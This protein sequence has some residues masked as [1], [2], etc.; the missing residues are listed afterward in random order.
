MMT[1]HAT[2]QFE[3]KSWTEQPFDEIDGRPKLSRGVMTNAFS[4]D[5][6]GEGRVEA[7]M[8]YRADGAISFVSLERVTGQVGDRTGSFVLQHSGVFELN[9][10]TARATWLVTPGS[11]AGDLR[12]LRGQGGYRWD[13]QRDGQT[14]PFTLDYEVEPP[15]ADVATARN[16]AEL[17]YSETGGLKLTPTRST[18]EITG[19]DQTPLDEPAAGP[20]LARATVKKIFRGDLEGE[21]SAELLLCQADDGSA[22]Y[23]GLERVVGRLAGRTGSF[24]V[25]HNAVRSDAAQGG[26]WFVVP[27]SATGELRGLRGRAE[28][29]HDEH[30]AVFTLDY[31]FE[32]EGV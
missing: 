4:G 19:W 25:Q 24:V 18:F 2:G 11:G 31:A 23:I 1:I 15:A 30:E 17:S 12:G 22:G 3:A 14:T 21:S 5:I 29:R 32:Q 13:R 9:Q 6:T 8:A 7:L 27:G 26:T 16:G 20:K 10:G 28:Y